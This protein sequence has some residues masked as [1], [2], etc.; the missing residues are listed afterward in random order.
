MHFG[1]DSSALPMPVKALKT[2][3]QNLI[4]IELMFLKGFFDLIPM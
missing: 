1:A 4:S 3:N 2:F